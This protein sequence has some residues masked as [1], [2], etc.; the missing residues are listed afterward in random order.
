M[1]IGFLVTCLG[2]DRRRCL[3]AGEVWGGMLCRPS[4]RKVVCRDLGE[5]VS[6]LDTESA[7]LSGALPPETGKSGR[8]ARD[9]RWTAMQ[10]LWQ[11]RLSVVRT[12]NKEG[13]SNQLGAGSAK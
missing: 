1:D 10:A 13:S 11:P 6:I 2:F 5:A 4:R 3:R 12:F 9:Q 7:E 8:E